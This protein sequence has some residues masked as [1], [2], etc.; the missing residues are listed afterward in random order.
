MGQEKLDK[1]N[2]F[3]IQS[4]TAYSFSVINNVPVSLFTG[5]INVSVPLFSKTIG[6]I[7][8]PME[9]TYLG[10]N[11]IQADARS[12]TLGKAWMLKTGG[13]ITRHKR[14]YPMIIRMIYLREQHLISMMG[15]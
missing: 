1:L 13:V 8:Y 10:G 9:A 2:S 3:N 6:G 7:Q 14:G 11:G 5:Q 4:P 15:S 12:T